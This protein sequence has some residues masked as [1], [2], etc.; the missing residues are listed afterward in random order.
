MGL[1]IA[2][3]S[4]GNAYVTGSTN[5][6][7][8]SFPVTMGPG[9]IFKGGFTGDAFVAKINAAG[10][11]LVYCG[12]IGGADDDMGLGIA[13]DAAGNAYVAGSTSSTEATFPVTTGPDLTYNGGAQD[14]F[15]AKVNATGTSLDYCG[16]IGGAG[17]DQGLGI[18][19][20]L[21]AMPI[22]RHDQF[23]AVKFPCHCW[24]GLDLQGWL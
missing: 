5:S 9:L 22:Y 19:V 1:G 8:D 24:S 2:V 17:S 21:S 11:G 10:T 3:D 4:G 20:D 14:A 18:A 12:Y 13:V 7:E 15:V 6:A 23:F 16:Y